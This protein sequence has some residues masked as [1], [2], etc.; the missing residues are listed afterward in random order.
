MVF[1]VS[2]ISIF[3][4]IQAQTALLKK[5]GLAI[6]LFKPQFEVGRGHH[7]KKGLVSDEEGLRVLQKTV[8]T[9]AEAGWDI[10]ATTPSV[11]RGED[12]NQEYFIKMQKR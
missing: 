12:G 1:D 7:N 5:G 6:V 8:T 2:F 3:P 11:I 9:I 4:V 10:Q